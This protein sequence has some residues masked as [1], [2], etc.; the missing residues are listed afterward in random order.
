MKKY[1]S[2]VALLIL[3]LSLIA[4]ENKSDVLQNL[5]KNNKEQGVQPQ[6]ATIKSA[7]RLFGTRED[8]S[9]VITVL[10]SG[11]S[12]GILAEDS[13]YYKVDANG[14]QGW[15]FRKDALIDN[16]TTRDLKSARQMY[17]QYDNELQTQKSADNTRPGTRQ[18]Y[19]EN[20]YGSSMAKLLLAG[21][22]WKGMTG[23]MV[24]DSWGSPSKVNK[25]FEGNLAKEEWT[26]KNTWLYIENDILTDWGP[27]KEQQ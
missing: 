9:S 12:V 13:T 1:F 17:N 22:I 7:T 15:I 5:E 20:K 24:R 2:V 6:T 18:A 23:D 26:Y 14:D 10:P 3:S 25:T 11:T 21:K 27:V 4:Q 16:A 19:L 8:V